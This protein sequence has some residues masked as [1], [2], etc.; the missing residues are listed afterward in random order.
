M[1]E[2][3]EEALKVKLDKESDEAN[4]KVD[5]DV[6]AKI[7]GDATATASIKE[8]EMT[9]ANEVKVTTESAREKALSEYNRLKTTLEEY[10]VEE[11]RLHGVLE[12][13]QPG[14]KLLNEVVELE[15][16]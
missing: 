5:N 13:L 8:E 9:T 2:Q 7:Y 6:A 1:G 14:E 15:Y 11:Q 3:K 10:A 16:E 4:L 12:T